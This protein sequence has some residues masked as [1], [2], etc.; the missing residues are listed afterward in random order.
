MIIALFLDSFCQESEILFIF[1]ILKILP[2]MN[3][4]NYTDDTAIKAL[5]NGDEKSFAFEWI[6][7]KYFRPLCLYAAK[8]IESRET[9]DDIVHDLVTKF[10]ENREKI[11][12]TD[13]LKAYLYWSVRNACLNH[14]AHTNVMR[15]YEDVFLQENSEA[16]DCDNPGCILEAKERKCS[17]YE[18]IGTLPKQCR[19]VFLMRFEEGLQYNEIASRLGIS[20]GSVKSQIYRAKTKLQVIREKMDEK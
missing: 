12:I 6:Y 18:V 2:K 9:A 4:L 8:I 13:S 20:M 11:D 3:K 5:K 16:S 14:I 19:E 10:W 1:A 17:I 7:N 15:E